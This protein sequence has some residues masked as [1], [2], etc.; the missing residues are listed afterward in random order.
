MK[1]FKKNS[2][3]TL[4]ELLIAALILAIMVIFIGSFLISGFQNNIRVQA[5]V[6]LGNNAQQTVNQINF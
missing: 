3:M 1:K 4:S 6:D 2:G 5:I